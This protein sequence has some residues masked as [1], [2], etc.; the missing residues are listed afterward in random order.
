MK[1]TV[2]IFVLFFSLFVQRAG[3]TQ[4]PPQIK[5][6]ATPAPAPAAQ[7]LQKKRQPPPAP[8]AKTRVD[9]S[10]VAR[11]AERMKS[12]VDQGRAAGV[13]TLIAHRGEIVSQ[14]AVGFR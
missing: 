5:K 1:K 9:A 10:R 7:S 2:V 4:T 14:N 11:I 13:V 6:P 8:S 3:A 12:F